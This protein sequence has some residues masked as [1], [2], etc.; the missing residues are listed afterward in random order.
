MTTTD[1]TS[2]GTWTALTRSV[3]VARMLVL[4][5][6][7]PVPAGQ[8]IDRLFRAHSGYVESGI[9]WSAV[10]AAGSVRTPEEHV[11]AAAAMWDP[12]RTPILTARHVVLG[13]ALADDVAWPLLRSGAIASM[14]GPWRPGAGT[15]EEPY[16]LVWDLLSPDGSRACE[17]RP[18][19]AAA[20]GAP[21]EWTVD[22]PGPPTEV[23]WSPAGDRVAALVG[24]TL[25]DCGPDRPP[26]RL[27]DVAGTVHALAWGHDGPVVLATVGGE[28]RL[29][30]TTV[31]HRLP[32]L[33]LMAGRLSADATTAWLETADAI[34]VWAPPAA[35]SDL[36]PTD[37]RTLLA[38]DAAGR[39][40]VMRVDKASVVIVNRDKGPPN[41][42]LP[43]P[44][45]PAAMLRLS[46][47]TAV[48]TDTAPGAAVALDDGTVV[49]RL[50]T[51]IAKTTAL[52]SDVA[53]RRL[54]VAGDH[55]VAVWTLARRRPTTMGVPAF[56]SDR[57]G[58]ED[59]LDAD[60][61]ARAIAALI[62]SRDLQPPLTVGL[63]GAWGSGKS[64]LLGRIERLIDQLSRGGP[65]SGY[66]TH[67][68]VVTFNA[69]VY[70]ES[71]LW[72][73]LVDMVLREIGAAPSAQTQAAKAEKAEED[74]TKAEVEALDVERQVE[75]AGQALA[76]VRRRRDRLPA[77]TML[78]VIAVVALIAVAAVA[79]AIGGV[80][81]VIGAAAAAL[82][83]VGVVSGVLAKVW[84]A[85]AQAR[86]LSAAGI[87][88]A[89]VLRRIFR[90]P[91]EAEVAAAARRLAE[92][93]EKQQR[94]Q[95]EAE[96]SRSR[97]R[98]ARTAGESR[99]LGEVLDEVSRVTEYRDQLGLVARTRERFRNI[100]DAVAGAPDDEKT[101][102]RVVIV[103]DDLDRCPAEKV[104]TVLEA[105]HLLFEFPMF[106]VLL[107][108]DTRWLDQS[109][110]IRYRQL[111]G[112]S[113]SAEPSDYL[114]KIIQLPIQL[115]PLDDVMVRKLI[116]G[117]TGGA[118]EP[119]PATTATIEAAARHDSEPVPGSD[120]P[121][122]AE[123]PRASRTVRA[124]ALSI[125]AA[126][127]VALAEVAPLIGRTPRTVKRFVNTYRLIKARV[128]DPDG[129]DHVDERGLGDHEAVAFLLAVLI[130][131]PKVFAALL[132]A[133][134]DTTLA[135]AL[136]TSAVGEWVKGHPR[137][138]DAPDRYFARW[139]EE[140]SRF[141]FT[142]PQETVT[143]RGETKD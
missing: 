71:N 40:G 73:S 56:D 81:R 127:G 33:S 130:G 3:S 137:F 66:L 99:P 48:A 25:Y 58:T 141:A 53:G 74:A 24:A 75:Q 136:K 88:G 120:G 80:G 13:L 97:A 4:A 46:K 19:L 140:V 17:E 67:V 21:P 49:A 42:D 96:L 86:R 65:D 142:A 118:P 43:L 104:V 34:L 59:L 45:G 36:V 139:A 91:D 64:F 84:D 54:A 51:G 78:L 79:V 8:V 95:A 135:G 123:R 108:V 129:F 15:A 103:I 5:D 1:L 52:A 89:G 35:P 18:L 41:P 85:V 116:T 106:V 70:A 28:T 90:R 114:E 2:T 111:L 72:A 125:T 77:R 109:L 138:A 121:L 100:N 119:E 63:F 98:R 143:V 87:A 101:L 128:T 14:L 83:A 92:L 110:R 39:H 117:I 133:P 131:H 107:A 113:G 6:A 27:R 69:W 115:L 50:S 20:F 23:C 26:R 9:D 112:D 102:D 61:D 93:R 11:V 32:N 122:R 16:R 57:T 37:F 55:H 30:R 7:T 62:A 60:R 126:E 22:L 132:R 94:T 38:V 68:K 124:E 10:T 105:V 76:D 31:T 134:K 29:I 44:P 47:Q 12:D 82:A